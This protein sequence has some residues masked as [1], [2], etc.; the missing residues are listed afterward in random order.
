MLKIEYVLCQEAPKPSRCPTMI[1]SISSAPDTQTP[2]CPKCAER[3]KVNMIADFH[4]ERREMSKVAR[5]SD[6]TDADIRLMRIELRD[7]LY[8]SLKYVN[9]PLPPLPGKGMR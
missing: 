7:R 2:F 9:K 1:S 3:M 4:D 6:W 5:A 8:E